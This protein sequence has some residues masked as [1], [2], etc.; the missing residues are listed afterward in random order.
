MAW[1]PNQQSR[2]LIT[3]ASGFLGKWV[4]RE[5]QERGYKNLVAT[6][7]SS[8]P[9]NGFD[10]VKWYKADLLKKNK[11][12]SAKA[13]VNQVIG[14]LNPEAVIH[15]AATVGGIGANKKNPGRYIY[16]NLLMG[17]NLIDRAKRSKFCQ[18]FIMTG[19]VCAYPK[20]AEVP[21]KEE[22]IWNGYPEE[23]NA[24]YGIAKKTLMEM[25]KAYHQ[26]YGFNGLNLIPVN[27]YGPEDNFDPES[28]HVIPALI[29]KFERAAQLNQPYV[30]VWGTGNA[31]RE[32][33]YVK[34]AAKG[35][36]DAL[37]KHNDPEPVNLGT[38]NEI[39]IRELA[40]QIKSAVGYR[41]DI[42]FNDKYPDGQPRRCLDTTKAE[43]L[44]GWTATTPFDVG[45]KE[46]VAWWQRWGSYA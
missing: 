24:P 20:H 36:V 28:S 22:D 44:F 1:T 8:R 25:V 23:T 10:G 21:F 29:R 13:S 3:G 5:L 16:E 43:Q 17:I 33:L 32:F 9:A 38:G 30:E 37:E 35:I 15:L 26:Q 2:I 42:V 41:G 40:K 45:L 6:F 46:T 34:D 12:V 11:G 27:L 19:T 4:L 39:T 31:S 7:R 14:T 18:K